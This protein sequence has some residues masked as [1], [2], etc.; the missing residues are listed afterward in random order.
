MASGW[1]RGAKTALGIC[2]LATVVLIA[3]LAAPAVARADA[4][5]CAGRS[6][7]RWISRTTFGLSIVPF[8][9]EIQARAALCV[10]LRPWDGDWLDLAAFEVGVLTY[11]SPVY[12]YGGGYVQLTPTNL[13]TF[14][15]EAAGIDYW[16]LP[17]EGAGYYA[18]PAANTPRNSMTLA[19]Q[20]GQSATGWMI[21]GLVTAQAHIP[22]GSVALLV[23]DTVLGERVSIGSGPYFVNLQ[24]DH[25]QAASDLIVGNDAALVLEVPVAGGPQLRFGGFDSVR[26]ATGT[27]SLGNQAGGLFVVGW[28][29]PIAEISW[30]EIGL[31]AGAYTNHTIRTGDFNLSAWITVEWDLGGL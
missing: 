1:T 9:A 8:G 20:N 5:A 19:V 4:H 15:V 31:R 29:R 25:T 3:A 6:T 22:L 16:N 17:I 26:A 7:P 21:R 13:L 28:P 10:P 27:G 23:W 18:L 14:R 24:I 30:M 2:A 12:L 11:L